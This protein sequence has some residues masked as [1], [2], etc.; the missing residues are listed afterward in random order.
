MIKK[1]IAI[2]YSILI[3]ALISCEPSIADQQE[4][5]L[6]QQNKQAA[7]SSTNQAMF[8]VHRIKCLNSTDRA[9][10]N[11]CN[12]AL[13]INP[14][15]PALRNR[16]VLL[17]NKLN[18]KSRTQPARR[19]TIAPV[20]PVRQPAQRAPVPKTQVTN[21]PYKPARKVVRNIPAPR[22][23]NERDNENRKLVIQVQ[24][25]LNT[26]GFNVGQA[27]GIAGKNT[28]QAIEDFL[29]LTKNKISPKL[30]EKLYSTLKEAQ[31]QH[32]IADKKYQLA[33]RSLEDGDTEESTQIIKQ[34]LQSAPWHKD[35]ISLNIEL[36]Q[37][38]AQNKNSQ[39]IIENSVT[40]DT[41]K[42]S[43]L[44]AEIATQTNQKQIKTLIDLAL[45][46]FDNKDI[47]NAISTLE[48]GLEL[49]P[50]N[51]DLLSLQDKIK[52]Y[53]DQQVAIDKL[54]LESQKM[55]QNGKHNN[56]MS[57]IEEGLVLNPNQPELLTL[58]KKVLLKQDQIKAQNEKEETLSILYARALKGFNNN[59]LDSAIA[60]IEKGLSLEPQHQKL[61]ELKSNI[62]NKQDEIIVQKN[63]ESKLTDLYNKSLSSF[64]NNEFSTAIAMINEGLSL[65]SDH[66]KLLEL[67]TQV[68][69]KQNEVQTRNQKDGQLA[70]LFK[71]ASDSLQNNQL[72]SALALI[73]EGLLLDSN[74]LNLIELK[75]DVVQKKNESIA[76]E[77]NNQKIA[78]MFN[79]IG[80]KQN[81]LKAIDDKMSTEQQLLLIQAQQTLESSLSQ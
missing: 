34:N 51:K 46:Q 15:V 12:K 17:S 37:K 52:I 10:L 78:M 20:R 24:K 77:K 68:L 42:D 6:I 26:L 81:I 9:A 50:D 4:E 33:K 67:K 23:N 11:A 70:S 76:L 57:L 44:K 45:V 61:L 38:I 71:K 53:N 27:D 75:R 56:S 1:N 54:V 28:M 47:K 32:Y 39:K 59:E 69:V 8:V 18:P 25:S 7:K 3:L 55:Y 43:A 35:F 48:K 13:S 30:D 73:D 14:N 65:D 64:K 66:P 16:R 2:A 58:K 36:K 31:E 74:K 80:E 29:T 49:S 5:R 21:K 41:E 79:L 22:V 60:F 62:T 19:V 63:R 72:D 40:A